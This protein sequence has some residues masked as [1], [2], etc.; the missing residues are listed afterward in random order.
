MERY[1]YSIDKPLENI[2]G[3]IKK[4]KSR[5]TGNIRRQT[6]KKHNTICVGHHYAQIYTNNLNK[7]YRLES[8]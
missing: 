6:K 1:A 3:K 5:K 4:W 8:K 7:V 2:E